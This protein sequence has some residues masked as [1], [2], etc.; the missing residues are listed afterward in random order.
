MSRLVRRW[1]KHSWVCMRRQPASKTIIDADLHKMT[2]RMI[3]ST[4][5]DYEV[6]SGLSL[7]DLSSRIFMTGKY[8]REDMLI[9]WPHWTLDRTRNGIKRMG[10]IKKI[11]LETM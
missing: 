5:D 3:N 9:F 7:K 10:E 4:K 11:R 8:D 6:C 1:L 2:A